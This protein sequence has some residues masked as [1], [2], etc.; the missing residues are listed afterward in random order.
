MLTTNNLDTSWAYIRRVLK[1]RFDEEEFENWLSGLRPVCLEGRTLRLSVPTRFLKSWVESH[2]GDVLL[3]LC[4]QRMPTIENIELE[5]RSIYLKQ[6]VEDVG[7]RTHPD[8][9]SPKK[10][11]PAPAAKQPAAAKQP[12][13]VSSKPQRQ[14]EPLNIN[15]EDLAGVHSRLKFLQEQCAK[16]CIAHSGFHIPA[17][18]QQFIARSVTTNDRIDVLVTSLLVH[19]LKKRNRITFGVVEQ[20]LHRL[21]LPAAHVR[22]RIEDIQNIVAAHYQI[23]YVDLLSSRIIKHVYARQV[24]MYLAKILT[25]FTYEHIG[26]CF[27]AKSLS[28]VMHAIDKVRAEIVRNNRLAE[29]IGELKKKIMAR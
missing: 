9:P 25:N 14:I 28:P 19:S 23:S 13:A 7:Q 18:V 10:P 21:D 20:Q 2:Y 1:A 4:Q 6:P 11:E 22:P 27:G 26:R 17:P 8:M 15:E 16:A 12:T 29:E 24:A 5:V 3:D